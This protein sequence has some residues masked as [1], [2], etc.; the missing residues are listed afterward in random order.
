MG[1]SLVQ[2]YIAKWGAVVGEITLTADSD[3]IELTGLPANFDYLNIFL[4]LSSNKLAGTMD[5]TI[6]LSA[7]AA[8]YNTRWVKISVLAVTCGE[9]F[10]VAAWTAPRIGDKFTKYAAQYVIFQPNTLPIKQAHAVGNTAD[11]ENYSSFNEVIL[12]GGETYITKIKLIR[13]VPGEQFLAGSQIVVY[14][15][16]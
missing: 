15:L 2:A 7:G 13:S 1:S 14:G 8:V 5:Y 11:G 10:G 9:D 12:P 3:S 4:Y 16:N 6:Q